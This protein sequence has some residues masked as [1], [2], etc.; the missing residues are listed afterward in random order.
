MSGDDEEAIG[1]QENFDSDGVLVAVNE[2]AVRLL[3]VHATG[4]EDGGG[5]VG[6]NVDDIGE[7]DLVVRHSLVFDEVSTTTARS[8]ARLRMAIWATAAS[9][10]PSLRSDDD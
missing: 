6:E 7:G 4:L 9:M 2:G 5:G 3:F 10:G 8:A 1:P